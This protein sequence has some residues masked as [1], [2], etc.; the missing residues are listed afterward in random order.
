MES[1]SKCSSIDSCVILRI[2]QGDIPKQARQAK[3]LLLGG[4]D[5]Y[6]DDVAI[7]EVVHVLTREHRARAEIAEALLTF[8]NNPMIIYDKEFFAP[9]F[10]QYATHPSLSFDDCVLAARAEAKGYTP[11]YTFD[12]K[13]A[14]QSP[15]A[16]LVE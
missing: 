5:F 11:L 14:H 16:K 4:Q 7:M 1:S 6:V 10:A 2:I 12:H 9:I 13:L 8:L 15:I 3:W